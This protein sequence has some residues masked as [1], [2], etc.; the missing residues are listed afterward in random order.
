MIELSLT[1]DEAKSVLLVLK[2]AIR[3]GKEEIFGE[4]E[5]H[6]QKCSSVAGPIESNLST[7]GSA[8]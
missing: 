5:D 3:R 1:E 6:S 4:Y 2:F 8:M 7:G